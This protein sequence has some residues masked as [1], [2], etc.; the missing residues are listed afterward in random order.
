VAKYQALTRNGLSVKGASIKD[1]DVDKSYTFTVRQNM[2]DDLF[3]QLK[4]KDVVKGIDTLKESTKT[5]VMVP[6]G[7]INEHTLLIYAK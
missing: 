6:N 1:F 3:K 5:K 4:K 7:R 2:K